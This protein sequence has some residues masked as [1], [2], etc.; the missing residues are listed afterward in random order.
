MLVCWKILYLLHLFRKDSKEQVVNIRVWSSKKKDVWHYL[1]QLVKLHRDAWN[2]QLL[3]TWVCSALRKQVSGVILLMFINILSVGVIET[4]PTSFQ[5]SVGT[6]QGETAKNLSIASSTPVCKGS[7]S[8]W[9]WQNRL[10]REVV[11]S[12]LEMFKSRL[13]AYVCSLL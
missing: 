4:W 2:P 5:Q 10:P 12:S 11:D 8:Q 1:E 9:G 6:G 3:H 13:D 7:S